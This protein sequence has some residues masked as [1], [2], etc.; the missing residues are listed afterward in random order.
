MAGSSLRL[1]G[2]A[3]AI[4]ALGFVL[5]A[6]SQTTYGTGTTP[7]QQTLEDLA[8]IAAF[9]APKKDPIDYKAR[10]A[11]VPPP[12]GAPLPP[13]EDSTAAIASA[14]WPK[15]PDVEEKK[16]KADVA[17]RSTG[18]YDEENLPFG[19]KD[20][21]FS[22]PGGQQPGQEPNL[23][24]M[25]RDQEKE[26]IG[27]PEQDAQAKKLFADSRGLVAVDAEGKPIRRYL[28]DP[29][30]EYRAPDPNAPVEIEAKP[31]KKKA[32]KWPWEKDDTAQEQPASQ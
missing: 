12:K 27:T 5:G 19:E 15:D 21:K 28:T 10:P 11:I 20:P 6:C 14:N 9:G 13:P 32:W 16:F 30:V 7:G 24:K 31:Q 29:P 26:A 1:L 25:E 4:G 23:A 22:L 2:T 8:G 17:A 3:A 18:Y